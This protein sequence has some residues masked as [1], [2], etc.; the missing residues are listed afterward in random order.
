MKEL[1]YFE[2]DIKAQKG[3]G[4]EFI[5]I[6]IVLLVVAIIC[7]FYGES[8]LTN[9]LKIGG[10]V[11]GLLIL[12]GGIA[13][14]NTEIKLLTT[15]TELFETNPSEFKTIETERMSKVV[16]DYPIYQVV[17]AAFIVLGILVVLLVKNPFWHGIAFAVMLLFVGVMISE[18]F[19]HRSIKTY[20]Q[21]LIENQ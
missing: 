20:N 17:F 15:Q 21:Y 6:G 9:G 18:A 19:S 14:K 16:K 3:V 13:Y 8:S 10:I 1:S 2:A 7:H 4:N 12:A 5:A 11:C